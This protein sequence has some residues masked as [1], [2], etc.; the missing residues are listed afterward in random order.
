MALLP[1]P[2]SPRMPST[3]PAARSKLTPFTACTV[4]SRLAKVTRRSRT[5]TTG[6]S[7]TAGA[8]ASASAL[9]GT[10]GPRG[11]EHLVAGDGVTGV[12]ERGE[13]GLLAL[14]DF[15]AIGQRCEASA[16]GG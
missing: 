1:D 7:V 6:A 10:A 3:S 4:R 16:D 13:G 9:G 5:D 11:Q 2:D 14:S 15:A 12:V 8:V